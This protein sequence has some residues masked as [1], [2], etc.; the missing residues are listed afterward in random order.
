MGSLYRDWN[1]K[2]NVI[3]RNDIDYLYE[4][5]I[6]HSLAIAKVVNFHA[7]SRILDAGT[8]GGFPGIPLAILFP[9]SNFVLN[10]SIGK[11]IK[12]VSAVSEELGLGNVTSLNGRVESINEKFDFVVSRAFTAFP[13]FVSLVRKNI[14]PIQHNAVPNGIIYLKGGDFNDEIKGFGSLIETFEISSYFNEPYFETKKVIFLPVN[15]K[16]AK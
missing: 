7:Q 3:S 15:N 9:D 2:I 10:D 12:V 5:H 8:G 16:H 11:K 6:L 4:R 1:D 13:K 14:S